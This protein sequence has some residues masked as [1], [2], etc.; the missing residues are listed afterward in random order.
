MDRDNAGR[1]RATLL[2]LVCRQPAGRRVVVHLG[3]V[4]LLDAAGVRVLL[5]VYE[6]AQ[7]RG[8]TVRAAGLNPLVRRIAAV[9]GLT[10]MLAPEDRA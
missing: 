10:P 7:V 5:A 3:G 4:P 1:L 9:A 2:E 8:V 6:A